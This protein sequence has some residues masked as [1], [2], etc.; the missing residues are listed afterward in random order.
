MRLIWTLDSNSKK[1]NYDEKI[2][3]INYYILSIH[4]AKELGYKTIMYCDTDVCDIFIDI[5]DELYL[6]N[7]DSPLWDS[8]KIQALQD[9]PDN[10]YY[11]I[12]GDIILHNKLPQPDSELTFDAFEILNW[13]KEYKPVID[14]LT[15]LGIK[16]FIPEWTGTRM[17]VINCGILNFKNENHKKIYL[18]KWNIFN[19]F[20]KNNIDKIDIKYATGVGAQ[21]LLSL[22]CKEYNIEIKP[23]CS[24]FG[25][26]GNYY[27]H[28]YGPTKYLKPIVSTYEV[29]KIKK[30]II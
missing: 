13:R 29:L 27:K 22:I 1:L 30:E 25:E 23:L 24:S 14:T 10:D 6:T 11:L 21:Y 8:F 17:N 2:I 16:E 28:H 4:K 15:E 12:D 7:S 5:V 18:E 9:Q 19:T 3:L 26:Y 20:V